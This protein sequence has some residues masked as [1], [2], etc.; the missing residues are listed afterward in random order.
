MASLIEYFEQA[1]LSMAAYALDLKPG[2]SNTSQKNDYV[3]ALKDKAEMS[4]AQAKSFVEN[5]SVVSQY[6]DIASGFSGTVFKDAQGELYF[7]IRGT[8]KSWIDWVNTN[9]GDVGTEGIAI[10][11]AISMLNWLQLMRAELGATDVVQYIYHAE[12]FDVN[13]H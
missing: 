5:Y 11:Q 9:F 8:E 13:S 6:T 3:A 7:A 1:Q 4:D 12:T 2:M 10:K